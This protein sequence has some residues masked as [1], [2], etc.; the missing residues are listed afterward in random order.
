[1]RLFSSAIDDIETGCKVFVGN[2]G[3]DTTNEDLQETF[4]KF[5]ETSECYIVFD[6]NT[7]ESRGFGFVT[8]GSEEEAK[9]AVASMNGAELDGRRL[10]VNISKPKITA[11]ARDAVDDC[12]VYVGNLGYDTKAE[13]LEEVFS[14]CGTVSHVNLLT[15][16]ETGN[17]RG[18]AFVTFASPEEAQT[19]VDT[20]NGTDI[21]GRSIRVNPT[22]AKRGNDSM[23]DD[24]GPS[25]KSFQSDVPDEAK[26]FIGNLGWDTSSDDLMRAFSEFGTVVDA[27]VIKDR[28]TG[29]SRGFGFISFENPAS[30]EKAIHTMDGMEL[31]GRDIR[32]TVSTPKKPRFQESYDEEW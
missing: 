23:M 24:R 13:A 16:F 21:D 12:K 30:A 19:A 6:R 3:W 28:E 15:D 17:S 2:L 7:G 26:L 10:R 4:G 29:N 22:R 31:G 11:Q 9:E 25:N 8:F 1:M 27:K 5:G 20:L 18:F 32:V 14:T